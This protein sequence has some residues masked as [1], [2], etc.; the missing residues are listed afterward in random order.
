MADYRVCPMADVE[1]QTGGTLIL[2]RPMT[3]GRHKCRLSSCLPVA[4]VEPVSGPQDRECA[5]CADC[6]DCRL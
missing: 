3:R 5:D 2:C 1:S 6:A 4:A